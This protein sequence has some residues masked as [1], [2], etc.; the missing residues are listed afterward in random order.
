MNKVLSKKALNISPSPTLAIS[1]KEKQMKSE[2]IDVIG[3]GAGEPD[4]DT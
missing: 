3:F 2:G 4:F 1:A